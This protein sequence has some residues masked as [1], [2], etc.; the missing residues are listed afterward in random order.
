MELKVWVDGVQRVV[1]GVSD[2]TT[3]QEVVI[4]LA[5]AIGQTGRYVLI[6]RLREKER[7]LLPHECPVESMAKC[8]QYANDVQF[9]LQRTGPSLT[10]RPSSDSAPQV[11][12]RTFVRASLPI[13]P[14][15][16]GTEVP[17]PRQ[18]KKSLT[19]SLGP[20]ASSDL[21]AKNKLRQHRKDIV[22]LRDGASGGRLSKEELFKTVL[23]QQEHL[24]SLEMQGDALE[25][26]LRHWECSRGSCQEGEILHL[27]QL[28]QQNESELSEEEFWQSELHTEKECERERQEKV[29]T[30][31][32]TMEEYMQKIHEL[33]VK[34]EALER[35]IQRE[36]SERA[37]RAKEASLQSPAELEEMAAKM[38]RDLE[39]RIK[40]SA[41]LENSLETVGKALEEAEQSLQAQNK[42]LEELNKE[43]RQCNLQQFIQQTGA[44]VIAPQHRSEVE[45]QLDQT[46]PELLA[47]QRNR[48]L[49]DLSTDLPPRATAK[50]FLGN[51]RNLQNPLVS[52]LNPEVISTKQSIWR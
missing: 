47:E 17:R 16:V 18:P 5:R 13:K 50:Q 3:C 2:Q 19:F 31:Q 14:R 8:G 12:E 37:K 23:H 30:L 49:L 33:R 39:A 35:E 10:E 42:E 7:Q 24:Y 22:A 9:L 40:Q 29:R 25:V 36:M 34:T 26:D 28:I 43:L 38:K 20:V 46:S 1:C 32:T 15:P 41:L 52:S 51:P 48:D 11:P 6:Q 21:L 44:T 4:A 45:P 27:E